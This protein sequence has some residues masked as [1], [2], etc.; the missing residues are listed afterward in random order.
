MSYTINLER[1][2]SNKNVY[3]YEKNEQKVPLNSL[4]SPEKEAE[5]FL[6]K[7]T[8][9]KNHFVIFIGFGN[10]ALLEKLIESKIYEQNIHFLFIEPFS[11]VE[12]QKEHIKI[13]SS[14][15]KISFIYG[16][17]FTSIL[18]ADY[19]SKL[20][21]ISVT[22]QIHP[23]YIK[24]N[25][26][27]IKDCLK[28]INEGIET[29]KILNTTEMK[30]ALDWILEPLANIDSIANSI[31]IRELEGKFNGER[32]MLVASGPSLKKHM[33]FIK[34]NKDSFHLFS[35]GPSLRP[36]LQ[37]GIA[38]DFALSIDSGKTNYESHFKDLDYKGPLIYETISNSNIQTNH[39]GDLIVVKSTADYLSSR[40]FNDLYT[41]N[42]SPSVAIF[43]LQVIAYL[44]FSEVY[45]VGQ[46]LAL[47]DG[48]YYAEGVKDTEISKDMKEELIVE[49]NQ[50]G[51]VG[52]TKSLK[53]FLESF[54]LLIKSLPPE[55]KIYN[56]SENGA[57]INGAEFISERSITEREKNKISINTETIQSNGNTK[58]FI[59]NFIKDIKSL[60]KEVNQILSNLNRHIKVGVI[61]SND[62]EKVLKDFRR[63]AANDMLNKVILSHLTFMFHR[64]T[65][66]FMM[67]ET[68]RKYTSKD[69]LAMIEELETL[70]LLVS[71][72]CDELLKDE[73]LNDKIIN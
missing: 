21:G 30:F 17:D 47:I 2:D 39:L 8:E 14:T 59:K 45:L 60:K 73:R 52:T 42:A 57:K 69:Y 27:K 16:K 22:I 6:K 67:M 56:L 36:L 34:K 71:N 3:V 62:M 65:N 49:D 37:N 51:Q 7:I 31:N 24:L 5:R 53:I 29:K 63:I 44:G 9:I 58:L 70:Y 4:Y 38:P 18:F 19:L 13:F 25:D 33:N 11:E 32:A 28:V 23:N 10:G 72:Y 15:K 40:L 12:L 43:T 20:I 50:G 66:T 46:D 26:Q 55:M 1:S 48:K 35:L 68:K 41:F 61:T 54:E 64:I